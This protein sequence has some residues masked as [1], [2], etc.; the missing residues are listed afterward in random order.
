MKEAGFIECGFR[1]MTGG[2]VTLFDG[3][4]PMLGK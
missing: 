2:I 3:Q 1:H 4:A